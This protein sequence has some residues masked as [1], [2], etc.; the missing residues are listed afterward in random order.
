MYIT[1]YIKSIIK[2]KI[3]I[4]GKESIL[5]EMIKAAG[6]MPHFF[7]LEGVINLK[8]GAVVWESK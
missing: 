8:V 7:D 5:E 4:F 2:D 1:S 3:V 6:R